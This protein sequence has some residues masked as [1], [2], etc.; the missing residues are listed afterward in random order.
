MDRYTSREASQPEL[1][2]S[3]PCILEE[4]F[5]IPKV[6]TVTAGRGRKTRILGI[7]VA[8]GFPDT[9]TRRTTTFSL[10]G[11]HNSTTWD[12]TLRPTALEGPVDFTLEFG[13]TMNSLLFTIRR[14]A[15]S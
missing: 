2:L 7:P 15:L 1:D 11:D 9:T 10:G 6:L 3:I 8:Q 14:T 13:A 4:L 12:G 5:G